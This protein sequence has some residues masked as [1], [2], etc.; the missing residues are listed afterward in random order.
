MKS[1]TL[2]I[3]AVGTATALSVLK[4]LKKQKKYKV[5]TIG[6]D[7][8]DNAAGKFFVDKFYTVP[9]AANQ[10][11]WLSTLEKI[12]LKEKV[13]IVVPIIDNEFLLWENLRRKKKFSSILFL[14]A[15]YRS[16]L[17]CQN[18][19]SIV[20]FFEKIKIPTVKKIDPK[21]PFAFPIFIKPKLL[22]VASKNAYKVLNQKDLDYFK[23]LMGGNYV[24]QHYIDAKEYTIDCLADLKGN[25]ITGVIR[26]RLE[27]KNGLAVK[28]EIIEDK[29][30]LFFAKK[31]VN[32]LQIPAASNIQYFK[33]AGNYYFFEVNPRF[34]GTHAFTIEAGL[35]SIF[36]ILEMYCKKFDSRC[37]IPI[38]KRL[39]MVRFWSEIIIDNKKTYTPNYLKL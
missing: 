23:G 2:L 29:K 33:K 17:I 18:K 4:G 32:E 10:N 34:A 6:I 21:K 26:K 9:L 27:V 19:N 22:G 15:P 37:K 16:L 7:I 39:K 35:N 20:D 24:L 30:A 25:F 14:L 11:L 3:S 8:F 31:I 13:N 36:Y 38:T 1:V 5:K 12:I 28:S